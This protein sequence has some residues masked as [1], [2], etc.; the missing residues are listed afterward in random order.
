VPHALLPALT[1]LL[2]LAFSVALFDQWRERRGGFQLIWGIGML[3]YGIAAGAEALGLP[4]RTAWKKLREMEAA[5][6]FL[7][8]EER[9]L[10]S[11]LTTP[12]SADL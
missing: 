6:G 1:S 2:A 8:E 11:R 5:A 9:R 10:Q 4:Y 7:V 12:A 3:F